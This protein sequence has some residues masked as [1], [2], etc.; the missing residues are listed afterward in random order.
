[1]TL[2]SSWRR[3]EIHNMK[4][5]LKYWV[6]TQLLV[7]GVECGAAGVMV[8]LTVYPVP[9][10]YELGMGWWWL[11][12]RGVA[13][14]LAALYVEF[15]LVQTRRHNWLQC[16]M[17]GRSVDPN[18]KRKLR[19]DKARLGYESDED[20]GKLGCKTLRPLWY[21]GDFIYIGKELSGWI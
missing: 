1:M 3:L 17:A 6:V 4:L 7:E 20:R 13:Y 2:L 5:D 11:R 8:S 16:T 15:A 9:Y 12:W 21:I 10:E 14:I 18:F 19:N